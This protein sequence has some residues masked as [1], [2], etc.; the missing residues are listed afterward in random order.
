MAEKSIGGY[1]R[2][3][4]KEV[5]DTRMAREVGG[6][7]FESGSMISYVTH[8]RRLLR[9]ICDTM[10]DDLQAKTLRDRMKKASAICQRIML[11]LDTGEVRCQ[12][13]IDLCDSCC[14][15][16]DCTISAGRTES[17]GSFQPIGRH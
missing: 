17:C 15:Q 1:I 9:S 11:L 13:E 2:D 10:E 12:L 4:A 16:S 6:D 8:Q 3:I 14:Q 5:Q 7:E